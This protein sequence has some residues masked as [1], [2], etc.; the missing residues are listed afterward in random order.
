MKVQTNNENY[1]KNKKIDHV[2]LLTVTY[3]K[4]MKERTAK[5]HYIHKYLDHIS[6]PEEI[7]QGI[8]VNERFEEL[9][10]DLRATQVEL[11]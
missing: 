2:A 7:Q 1:F 10:S 5:L 4:K 8:C 3:N 11:N 6:M 9:A